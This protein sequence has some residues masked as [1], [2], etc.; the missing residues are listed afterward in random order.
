MRRVV[1]E[2]IAVA[3]TERAWRNRADAVAGIRTDGGVAAGGIA[4]RVV[5]AAEFV[6]WRQGRER[7]ADKR[8]IR[9]F[10]FIEVIV[11]G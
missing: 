5:C 11:A 7:H 8:C 10:G 9:L 4:A 3:G 1:A 6:G 2:R